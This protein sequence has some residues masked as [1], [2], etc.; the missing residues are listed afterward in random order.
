METTPNVSVIICAY[1]EDRWNELVAAVDSV[2]C[3]TIS[4]Y[5]IILVIDHNARLVE[6]AH[7]QFIDSRVKIVQNTEMQGLSG[8]RNS[9]MAVARGEIF[10][11]LDDDAVAAPDWLEQL[12][13]VY[14]DTNV[15][16]VGGAILPLWQD[17][18]PVWFPEEFDW[19]VGCTY[20]GMPETPTAVRNL[21]GCNMSFHRSVYEMIGTFTHGIG[22]VGTRPVGCEE[23]EYCIRASKNDPDKIFLY[24]PQA[25]VS[26]HVPTKRANWRYFRSRCYAEGIS[27]ALVTQ[28]VGATQGLASE[29]TYVSRTLPIGVIREI[30]HSI[31]HMKIDGLQRAAAIIIGLATTT[32]GYTHG[33]LAVLFSRYRTSAARPAIERGN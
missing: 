24:K 30:G 16:G 21:I 9:G 15:M 8:S 22:R 17:G 12:V 1:S 20:R 7:R 25:R 4:L 18:R 31:R 10:A 27:K 6:R 13:G 33:K 3:Q 26:H 29:R 5:E 14:C 11:F 2:L 32:A 23:T 28:L 19:V